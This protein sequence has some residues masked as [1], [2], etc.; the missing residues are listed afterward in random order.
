MVQ[1]TTNGQFLKVND[2]TM[3]YEEYGAGEPVVLLHAAFVSSS[4]WAIS[5]PTF[6]KHFRVIAPDSRAHGRT[7]NPAGKLSYAMMA[8]DSAAFIE[9]LNLNKPM[10]VG[11]S[12]GGQI[13]LEIAMRYPNLAKAFVVGG[14]WYKLSESLM[15]MMHTIGFE[16]INVVNM[17]AFERFLV[18]SGSGERWA[19]SH[20]HGP[21]YLKTLA[22]QLSTPFLTNLNY[23]VTDFQKIVAP[24]LVLIG[25]RDPVVPI[26]QAVD[27]YRQIPNAELA[28]SPNTGHG[29][30]LTHT[31]AFS[32][33]TLEFL[34]RH[35]AKAE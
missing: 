11:W 17:E 10:V 29:F 25:D 22:T 20:H 4:S 1:A 27:M 2:L 9:A 19:A 13:A 14:V 16:G 15:S 30:P 5:I 6:S 35:A 23:S 33:T 26:E 7:D 18:E 31:E 28:V 3:Y 24:T 34:S 32:A 12:D 21:D 8:D